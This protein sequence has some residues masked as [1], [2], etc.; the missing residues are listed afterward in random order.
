MDIKILI[1]DDEPVN[2]EL[3]EALLG[4]EEYIL[5]RAKDGE[6]ALE[7]LKNTTPDMVLLDIMMPG[8][9]GYKVL[10]EIR[11]NEKTSIIPVILLTALADREHRIK[12]LKAG[13]SDY[14]SKPFDKTELVTKVKTLSTMSVLRR[15]INE[16]D[17]LIHIMELLEEGIVVTDELFNI[18]HMNTHAREMRGLKGCGKNLGSF[19]AEKYRIIISG[20]PENFGFIMEVPGTDTDTVSFMSA[21]FSK[22]AEIPGT[23]GSY[24]F[25][26]K[27][28][29]E[30]YGRNMMKK[31][32]ISLISDRLR[33]PLAIINGYS[34]LI[35]TQPPHEQL[36][37]LTKAL[38]HNGRLIDNLIGRVLYFSELDNTYYADDYNDSRN[39]PVSEM[40][41]KQTANMF[42]MAY[43]K[44]YELITER[45]IINV[46]KWQKTAIKE[47]ME[48]AFKFN[49]QNKLV[50]KVTVGPEWL[51]I[52]DNGPGIDA[53]EREKVFEPFYQ[54]DM[55][56][57]IKNAG[58]G[59]GLAIVKRL[60][61]SGNRAVF[62][63]SSSSGGLRV[64]IG[65]KPEESAITAAL[66]AAGKNSAVN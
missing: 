65:K 46:K 45:E 24:V 1:V 31:D 21:R 5:I 42:E 6:E 49:N 2:I 34:N 22:A 10:E 37:E 59:L 4:P 27:D 23:A 40:D 51:V 47:I 30:D 64:I 11:K 12:G 53:A 28:V 60:A 20:N 63:G 15:Q 33:A 32:F 39:I 57:N 66:A 17:K 61:E 62:L 36:L 55:D 58:I 7:I 29:S 14:I 35:A 43:K 44:Q 3:L 50:L 41:L 25:V 48:N 18:Q 19:L 52:E 54:P 26:L 13:A 38:I 8:M 16:K 56:A 9:S